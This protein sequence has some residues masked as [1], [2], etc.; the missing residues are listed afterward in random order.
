[1]ERKKYPKSLD[2]L[3]S[4]S[5]S[6][7]EGHLRPKI[8]G[9]SEN[10]FNQRQFLFNPRSKYISQKPG[11]INLAGLSFKTASKECTH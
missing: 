11:N 6:E 3:K 4:F 10:F 1:M 2:F 5:L 9:A 7:D 8:E